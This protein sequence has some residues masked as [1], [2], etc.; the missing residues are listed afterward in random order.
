MTIEIT[1]QQLQ[2]LEA[3]AQDRVSAVP[4]GQD[5]FS[6]A[7]R[8]ICERRTSEALGRL[9]R[10]VGYTIYSNELSTACASIYVSSDTM[11]RAAESVAATSEQ[12]S[13]SV[14]SINDEV[15]ASRDHARDMHAAVT[16]SHDEMADAT[17]ATRQTAQ[18]LNAATERT[19]SL[20]EAAERIAQVIGVIDSIALQTKLLALNASVEAARAGAV[21]RGF[22]VVAQE[23]RALSD[24]TSRATSDIRDIVKTLQGEVRAIARAVGGAEE[25]ARDGNAKL[26][27]LQ[28][29]MAGLV[30][31]IG[32]VDEGLSSIAQ[33]ASEQAQ[34]AGALAGAAAETNRLADENITRVGAAEEALG[35]LISRAGE[36][37]A[38]VAR[39][40]A[41]NKVARLAKAD[42]VI[43]KKR[44]ADMFTGRL[45]LKADELADHRCCRLGKWYYGPEARHLRDLPVFR[46]LEGPH[47]RVHAAGIAAVKAFN[48]GQRQEALERINE[49]ETASV[50]VLRLL[51]ALVEEGDKRS[52]GGSPAQAAA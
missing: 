44:L 41:P 39:I 9:D 8:Q 29:V 35:A 27:R 23:V 12:L 30:N 28:E 50:E 33:G 40:D 10:V 3:V 11:R 21:G 25:A 17:E 2:A 24:Q 20:T 45:D 43:W 38:E 13:A 32:S 31:G 14:T 42:H 15:S 49:V 4:Q 22:A 47:A 1:E 16:A 6:A 18:A 46:A 52:S 51:D 26:G 7:L 36:E 48:A 5:R 37:L 34:A 19:V